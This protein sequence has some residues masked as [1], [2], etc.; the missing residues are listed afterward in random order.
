MQSCQQTVHKI[1]KFHSHFQLKSKWE[2]GITNFSEQLSQTSQNN[3]QQ[4]KNK[5]KLNTSFDNEFYF[6]WKGLKGLEWW[7]CTSHKDLKIHQN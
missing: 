6:K 2:V 5:N 7:H 4:T 1:A 3:S